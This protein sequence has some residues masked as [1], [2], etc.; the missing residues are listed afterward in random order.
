MEIL[1]ALKQIQYLFPDSVI[2]QIKIS[3][4]NKFEGVNQFPEERHQIQKLRREMA[5]SILAG[6]MDGSNEVE[7]E[8]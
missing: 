3:F 5:E 7:T 2:E 4:L 1:N 8:N 6:N